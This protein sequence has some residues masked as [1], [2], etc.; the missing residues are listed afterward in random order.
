MLEGF[1]LELTRQTWATKD[2]PSLNRV[3]S[4]RNELVDHLL[5]YCFSCLVCGI[6]WDD[7]SNSS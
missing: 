4:W 1:Q 7:P 3:F 5:T 6:E 2:S